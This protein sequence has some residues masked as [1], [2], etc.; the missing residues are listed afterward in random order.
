MTSVPKPANAGTGQAAV[1]D[2]RS[3]FVNVRSGPGTNYNDIGDILDKTLVTYYPDSLQNGWVWVEQFNLGGWVATSVATFNNTTVDPPKD[4]PPT[5]Y[6]GGVSVFYWKG[7]AVSENTIDEL[8]QNL[9]RRAPNVKHLFVKVADGNAWQGNFDTKTAMAVNSPVDVKKWVDTLAKYGI[10]F[11]AWAVLKGV[12]ITGEASIIKQTCNVPGVKS[13]ILDIEPYEHYWEVGPEPIAPLMQDVRAGIPNGFHIS[14]AVD[15]R[16]THYKS[17]FPEEW[18]PYVDSVHTQ[19]YWRTFRRSPE[20]VLAETYE[21]WGGFGKPVIPIL[22]GASDNIQEQ[23]HAVAIATTK[24]HAKSVSWWR[25]GV[26]SA[27]DAMNVPIMI[28]TPI[29]E[30]TEPENP[31]QTGF[32]KEV[33]IFPG[34]AGYRS[35]TYTG[36]QEFTEFE[37]AYG[38]K[39]YYTTT[40]PTTSKVWAEWKTALPEDGIYQI[41]VFIPAR[42]ATTKKARYKI[43]GIRG[44]NTEVIVDINQSIHRN[45]WVPLGIFDLVKNQENAGKVFLNDVTGETGKE[46][47][48]DAIRLRQI[49]PIPADPEPDPV[50]IPDVPVADGFDAPVGTAEERAGAINTGSNFWFKEWRDA[51]GFGRNTA[52]SYIANFGAY[53]TGVDLNWRFGNAD[54]GQPVYAAASGTVIY[55]ANVKFWGNVTVIRHDPLYTATGPVYYTRYG[56][57]QNVIVKVGDRVARGQQIGEVGTGGGRFT[58]HLHYDVVR[59][60]IMETKPTDWPK[61]DIERL[62]RDYVD[63]LEFT[64]NNRPKKR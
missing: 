19:S 30:P 7:Q 20:D 59:T 33:V 52:S 17:V 49:I 64:V 61:M 39:P 5:P 24:H 63:P 1:I 60:A 13:F 62:L 26:I 50:V 57:M 14:M 8:A 23:K 44:T 41:S 56:H 43:H 21:V 54:I 16:R 9:Q 25:Y 51:T 35:G 10:N 31:P 34:K 36:K 48:F 46:I 18:R 11:H 55:Q 53:H 2:T 3:T 29:T 42:H 38:W 40:E 12:D 22:Q 37:G 28:D 47:A 15:P 4:F 32:G 6:D 58:A 27:W 45:E